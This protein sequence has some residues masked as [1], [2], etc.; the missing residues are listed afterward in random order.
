MHEIRTCVPLL[1]SLVVSCSSEASRNGG[2]DPGVDPG[3][4]AG[5][6]AGECPV[7]S[8]RN[9]RGE[10]DST[11]SWSEGPALPI[12]LHHHATF[13][14]ASDA[15]TWLYVAGGARDA[16]NFNYGVARAQVQE[17]GSLVEWRLA[18]SLA[19]GLVGLSV[20]Q[21]GETVVV[22]GGF[23]SSET[24]STATYLTAVQ[25]DGNLAEWQAGP[26]IAEGRMHHIT[27]SVGEHVY[28]IGGT[29]A[30]GPIGTVQRA[31]V[32]G[33]GVIEP[34]EEV[35]ALPE[36]RSH[37]SIAVS[38]RYLFLTG[39]MTSGAD[40]DLRERDVLRAEVLE[41]G[42][43][44]GWTAIGTLPHPLSVHA[45]FV[46]RGWLYLV[47]GLKDGGPTGE[48][49]RAPIS[50]DGQVGAWAPAQDSLPFARAHVHQVPVANDR[51]LYSV[52]GMIEH[53]GTSTP[54]VSVGRFE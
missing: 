22:T 4:D 28:L 50:E 3:V 5:A 16:T 33:R 46:R 47:G 24:Y 31:R 44:S 35:G 34:W 29:G 8:H 1:L 10:C 41:N 37:H 17:D 48:L 19:R 49:I 38:G 14:A 27:V 53:D 45:S 2:E 36:P 12:G 40:S 15:G 25:P 32:T 9:E 18:P 43:L 39:G 23:T 54:R 52:G 51:L 21:V 20:A 6:D 13:V 7:A 11:V 42:L 30:N 26:D